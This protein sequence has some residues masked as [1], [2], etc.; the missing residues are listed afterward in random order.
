MTHTFKEI[1]D[2]LK[3]IT[4]LT[5]ADESL[6]DDMINLTIQEINDFHTWTFNRRKTSFSTV[7][8]TEFYVLPRDVDLIGLIRQ[9][10]SPSRLLYLPD[11]IF[12]RYVPNPTATGNPQYY[13]LWEEEGVSTRLA[14]DGTVDIVSSSTSDTSSFK[15]TVSGYDT[16]GA[17]IS[18]NYSLNGTTKVS[19]TITFDAGFPLFISKS[20]NTTGDITVTTGSTTLLVLGRQ[21][22]S[23]RFKCIGLYPIP[24][25]AITMLLEYFGRIKELINDTDVPNIPNE[26]HWLIKDGA[27]SKIYQFQNKLNDY[28]GAEARYMNGLNKM[29]QR[30]NLNVDYIPQL[31]SRYPRLRQG[32]VEIAD[33]SYVAIL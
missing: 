23:P 4:R 31:A 1:R 14:T 26:W 33:D 13:R 30:D 19:G 7:A 22:R 21:E 20:A 32:I 10:S 29:K 15:V 18:E 25:S 28:Q 24:S 27:L 12:Y 3:T 17:R 11:E 5:T 2:H 6:I 8:S 16:N 9:T